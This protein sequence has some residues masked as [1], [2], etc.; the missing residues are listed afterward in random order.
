MTE[1]PLTDY[2][3][4]PVN[5][6]GQALNFFGH[7]SVNESVQVFATCLTWA[8]IANSPDLVME[9]YSPLNNE[10]YVYTSA[11]D[12]MYDIAGA[13]YSDW[14]VKIE[15]AS[16]TEKLELFCWLTEH[17]FV[18]YPELVDVAEVIST[19]TERPVIH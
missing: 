15:D 9:E 1:K 8:T 6:G 13:L 18:K 19:S 7:I 12:L 16:E 17:L 3:L 5:L 2:L 14:K 11:E 4:P 10:N